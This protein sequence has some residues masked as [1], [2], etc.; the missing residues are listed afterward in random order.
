ALRTDP[1]IAGAIFHSWLN[2]G[3]TYPIACTSNP[4]MIRHRPQ[5][6][7]MPIWNRLT[8]LRSM[9][10][11]T[12]IVPLVSMG[13]EQYTSC[14]VLKTPPPAE[15]A[16]MEKR[17]QPSLRSKAEEFRMVHFIFLSN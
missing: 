5:R 1:K 12:L 3:A 2:A 6:T 7:K 10:S 8:G 13:L 14:G 9:S 15:L 4:S 16:E 11:D 17:P